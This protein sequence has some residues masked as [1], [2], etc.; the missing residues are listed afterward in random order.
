VS[1]GAQ[2]LRLRQKYGH[3]F[4]VAH[5]RDS[6]RPRIL[7]TAP[8]TDTDD[9]TC[10]IHVLTSNQ[11][12]LNLIWT[13]KSFYLMSGRRY[14]LCIHEDGS[15]AAADVDELRR[16]FPAARIIR[17]RD[18]DAQ[19]PEFLRDYPRCLK[20]RSSNPL[21]LKIFDSKM[22]LSSARMLMFDSDLLFFR[23]PSAFLD[24]AEDPAYRR[25]T[26]NGDVATAYSFDWRVVKERLGFDVVERINSG[27]G[28]VHAPSIRLDWLE[29]FL[30]LERILDGHPWRIEQTLF[31][32]LSSRYGV[33]LL[34]DE[35]SVYL[36]PGLGGR[37]FRHYVGAIRHL[38]YGEGMADLVKRGFLGMSRSRSLRTNMAS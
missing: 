30:G 23:E 24:R 35:Y 19:A 34:P 10:E 6:V 26:F 2:V 8:I 7:K 4:R 13:L 37:P 9:H 16:H 17:R 36:N 18:A 29:E 20:F 3:G 12:W 22:Y 28:V 21:S 38:M 31:A 32:L 33:E 15:I 1:I 27:F 5:I 25:N 14:A 11:D